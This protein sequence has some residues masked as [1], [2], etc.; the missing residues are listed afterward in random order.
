[1]DKIWLKQYPNDVPTDID[2][3]AYTSLVHWFEHVCQ[4][5]ADKSA[6]RNFGKEIS[7]RELR[8]LSQQLAAY[9][10]VSLGLKKGDRVAVMMPNLLQYPIVIFAILQAGGIVVNT[11]PLYTPRELKHQLNDAG[12]RILIVAE[13]FADTVDKVQA[14]TV[15]EHIITTQIGDLLGV[16]GF[17][18]DTYLRYIK[19]QIPSFNFQHMPLKTALDK[20]KQL[21]FSPVS[22]EQNDLAFLQYTGGTTGVAKG[23]ML[24]H[25]NLLANILQAHH[26]I[27]SELRPTYEGPEVIITALPLY[28]IFSLTANCFT[29]MYVGGLNV[30]ITNPRDL[31]GMIKTLGQTPFTAFTGVNTLFNALV[32]REAFR[33]LDFKHLRICLGGGSSVQAEVAKAWQA[34]TG[35]PLLEAYGMTETS[36]AVC[37]NL[38]TGKRF[39]GSIGLPIPST[40]V[41]IQDDEGQ[42]LPL[43]EKGELCVKGPQVMQ[44][45][46]QRPEDTKETIV[47]GWLH[48]GD[49]AI[50]NEEGF[51]R[52]V[53]RK[54]DMIL[55]SGFNVYPNEVEAEAVTHPEVVEAAAVGLADERT[56]ERVCLC[57]VS[58][59]PD[60]DAK[61]L[62]AYCK[63]RLT[64]YK[65]PKQIEFYSSLPKSNVGKIL[66]REI[67]EQLLNQGS[68]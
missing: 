19:G 68:T 21:S 53:D 6:F 36:P 22:L 5:H 2:L 23:A 11:N 64:A 29:F 63:E 25:R 43:G 48:S 27:K 52:I 42:L 57:V 30:L 32:Q 13:N 20:G 47:D 66:R 15:L 1:M 40:E 39:N 51:V 7:Y 17:L 46:W 35:V 28:H 24:A 31:K 37:I 38:M 49:I 56:G 10:Q 41:S 4:Q 34:C 33:Q 45:Y 60:L 14:E 65:V 3:T 9:F 16:K 61:T 55:V 18:L 54:K 58:S 8:V 12:V 26:W 44:G 59:N 62:R 67:K 50:M